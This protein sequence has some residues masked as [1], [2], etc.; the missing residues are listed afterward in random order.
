MGKWGRVLFQWKDCSGVWG[1]G[2]ANMQLPFQFLTAIPWGLARWHVCL[3]SSLASFF[4]ARYAQVP[5]AMSQDVPHHKYDCEKTAV[6]CVHKAHVHLHQE[7][8]TKHIHCW[9]PT[10][11]YP[12]GRYRN[13][14]GVAHYHCYKLCPKLLQEERNCFAISPHLFSIVW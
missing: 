13:Y 10:S 5:V 8:P 3:P 12:D 2:Y 1:W 4:P 14:M 6:K 11:S 9:L 7:V